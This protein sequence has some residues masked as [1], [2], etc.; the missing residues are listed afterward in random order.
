VGLLINII[1]IVVASLGT[2]AAMRVGRS[3]LSF[4]K[5]GEA[6]ESLSATLEERAF[7]QKAIHD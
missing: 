4:F 3:S 1:A 5:T 6:R 2:Y 7:E